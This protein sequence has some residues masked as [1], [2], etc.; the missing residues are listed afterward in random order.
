MPELFCVSDPGVFKN[1]PATQVKQPKCLHMTSWRDLGADLPT[2]PPFFNS[3]FTRT[4]LYKPAPGIQRWRC[5]R[6]PRRCPLAQWGYES[7]RGGPCSTPS[8]R[9]SSL[10]M[11]HEE[12]G[13]QEKK[14][15]SRVYMD[16]GDRGFGVYP[17]DPI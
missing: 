1:Y 16:S 6:Q 2:V 14:P 17:C 5:D 7:R 12:R 13:N 3:H 10:V 8:C 4:S 11:W 15:C 9:R